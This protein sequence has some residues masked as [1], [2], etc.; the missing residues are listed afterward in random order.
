[1]QGNYQPLNLYI[2]QAKCKIKSA[3]PGAGS[4]QRRSFRFGARLRI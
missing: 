2:T 1:M 3:F 4:Y